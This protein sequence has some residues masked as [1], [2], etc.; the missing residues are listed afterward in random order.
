VL[1]TVH[2]EGLERDKLMLQAGDWVTLEDEDIILNGEPPPLCLVEQ[3]NLPESWGTDL[4]DLHGSVTLRVGGEV[5]QTLYD[6]WMVMGPDTTNRELPGNDTLDVGKRP[7]LRRWDQRETATT[8]LS[9]G[10]V[11][12]PIGRWQELERGIEVYFRGDG[13]YA[14]GDYWLL[15]S[16]SQLPDA[17]WPAR[18]PDGITHHYSPLALLHRRN[19]E[20]MMVQETHPIFATI[21][22]LTASTTLGLQEIETTRANLRT[23]EAT[24]AQLAEALG[25]L[26]EMAT[27]A[28]SHVF[29]TFFAESPL[30]IGD[31]VA[32]DVT[33]EQYVVRADKATEALVV[34]VVLSEFKPDT[35]VHPGYRVAVH[36]RAHCKV[37]GS[38]KI[39]DLLVI[40]QM[41][42]CACPGG[43]FIRPGAIIGKALEPHEPDSDEPGL[44]HV[45]VTLG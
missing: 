15:P 33:R 8:H 6:R 20:W 36:G 24:V 32:L 21:P 19:G 18:Q 42:G 26:K 1:L 13:S 16:R 45:L 14:T 29:H 25:G 34:G 30:E 23:L 39:G 9:R 7:L 37:K 3:V 12:T 41:D 28:R 10:A 27:I 31:V 2:V 5:A 22:D 43:L 44:I 11:R 38:V 35:G 40:S 4:R 17:T